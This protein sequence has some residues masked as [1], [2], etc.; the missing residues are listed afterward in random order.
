MNTCSGKARRSFVERDSFR[1]R[2]PSAKQLEDTMIKTGLGL[3]A[4][5]G[6][7]IATPAFAQVSVDVP[8]VSVG[9]GERDH[10]RG[11]GYRRHRGSV[12]VRERDAYAA[13]RCSTKRIIR[14]DGSRTTIRRCD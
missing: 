13:E 9:I 6:I 14:S 1:T 12:V 11:D 2:C 7:A 4:L 10:Y 8:G 3:M 5:A